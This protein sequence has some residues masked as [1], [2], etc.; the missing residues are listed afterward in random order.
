MGLRR[1]AIAAVLVLAS[2]GGQGS[3]GSAT[4]VASGPCP[5]AAAAALGHS[6]PAKGI[7]FSGIGGDR[8]NHVYAVNADGTGLRQLTSAAVNDG[9]PQ[10][11][12][13]GTRVAFLREQPNTRGY[14]QI[15]VMNS[16]GTGVSRLTCPGTRD[17]RPAWSPDGSLIAFGRYET[18]GGDSIFVMKPDGS[19]LHAVFKSGGHPAAIDSV[20]WSP[21]GKRFVFADETGIAVVNVDG[22]GFKQLTAYNAD[23]PDSEPAWS[24]DGRSI[25]FSRSVLPSSQGAGADV[26]LWMMTAAG[27]NPHVFMARA[28]CD[29]SGPAWSAHGTQMVYALGCGQLGQFTIGVVYSN[30]TGAHGLFGPVTTY[31]ASPNWSPAG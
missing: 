16:D 11:S 13:D 9:V 23:M 10:W 20:A 24:P 30:G 27:L 6:A 14:M 26:Q 25:A 31:V 2:C 22:T 17:S 12:P 3:P 18:A 8:L 28:N 4:L 1:W 29:L 19:A 7:V 21:D 15:F 5:G